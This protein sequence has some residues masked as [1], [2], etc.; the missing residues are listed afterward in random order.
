MSK[1]N[2]SS[3]KIVK[4]PSNTENVVNLNEKRLFDDFLKKCQHPEYF[5]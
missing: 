5:A 1:N 3:K 2:N 4:Y